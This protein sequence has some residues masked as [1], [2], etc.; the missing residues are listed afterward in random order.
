MDKEYL[1]PLIEILKIRS[2]SMEDKYEAP[3]AE[4]R[5]FLQK[6]LSSLGFETKIL[7]GKKHDA[8]FAQ[9]LD[10]STLPTVLI[11]GHYDIQPP[12]PLGEWLSNPFSP[13]IRGK[14]LYARG[15]TDNKGQFMIHVMAIKKLLKKNRHLPINV[16]F[17]IEGE[18]E[19]GSI[20]I[21][22]LAQKYARSLFSCDYILVS[23]SGM[24]NKT[25]PSIDASLRGLVYEEVFFSTAKQDGHSG[26]FGGV[27]EN[28]AIIL[29]RV[30]SKLK[31][32]SNKVLIPGFYKNIVPPTTKE[33]ADFK[34]A[35]LTKQKIMDDGKLFL[36]GGGESEYSLNE[37][38]WARPTLDVN[39]IT[40]GYQGE[41]SK[42]IIPAAASAKVSMR[43]VPNQDPVKISKAFKN[44]VSKLV[45]AGVKVRFVT[46]AMALPY[47]VPT[48]HPIFSLVKKS[49]ETSF[50]REPVF[51][52]VGG[53]IGFVPIVANTLKVPCIMVGFGL[54]DE[55]FHAPNEHFS[56]D[57]YFRGIEAMADF[58]TNLAK[59]DK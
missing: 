12:E 39:G 54:P 34:K 6:L 21:E 19:I 14:Q 42:T 38:A 11:Y 37:R 50:G 47:K 35:K 57:N 26:E 16:K 33:L 58:Y 31:N 44:Y 18:E 56:L 24:F 29:S 32:G 23:D 45:P 15:A 20:S 46:H 17:L 53:S 3:M 28:P 1:K 7:K 9:K 51:T 55:N 30:I 41:G 52:G 4:A 8:V 10:D 40:S 22:S 27:A 13:T 49:L 59:I 25:T 5:S 48:D 2:V 36:I 43:L